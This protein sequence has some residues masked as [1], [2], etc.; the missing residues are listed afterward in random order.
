MM[1]E[2]VITSDSP[3]DETGRQVLGA[4]L[5]TLIPASDDGVMPSAAELDLVSYLGDNAPEL[6]PV[7]K[8]VVD[9]FDAEFAS[10]SIDERCEQLGAFSRANEELFGAL[11]FH[12]YACYYQEDRVLIGVGSN[13]GPPYPRGNTIETGDLSLVNPVLELDKSY[14]KPGS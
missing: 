8:S 12:T 9:Q 13:A 6:I 14:R 5:D 1:S 2:S 4:L 10:R 3:F 7:I 11:L